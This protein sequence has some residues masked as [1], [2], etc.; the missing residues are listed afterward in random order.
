M[1][2]SRFV[3]GSGIYLPSG[4]LSNSKLLRC[5]AAKEVSIPM[6]E[7]CDGGAVVYSS[8]ISRYCFVPKRFPISCCCVTSGSFLQIDFLA[9]AVALAAPFTSR[10]YQVIVL[11]EA[12]CNYMNFNAM[13][14]PFVN[15]VLETKL[16][17][18]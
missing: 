5:S 13:D 7:G 10:A 16:N 15:T 12:D 18:K 1:H 6:R 2:Q 4:Q 14:K 8:G 11:V 3:G 17:S 9:K